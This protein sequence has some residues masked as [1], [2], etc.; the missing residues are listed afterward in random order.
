M[1]RP[2]LELLFFFWGGGAEISLPP[3]GTAPAFIMNTKLDRK[4]V[5]TNNCRERE[6]SQD[7]IHSFA[8][9]RC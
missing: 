6:I 9:N 3:L 5:S 4:A 8:A 1:G 2:Y 7:T